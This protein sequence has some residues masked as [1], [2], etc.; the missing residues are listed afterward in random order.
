MKYQKYLLLILVILLIFSCQ[1]DKNDKLFR[2]AYAMAP[3]GTSH[4]GAVRLNELVTQK[5]KGRIEVKLY[6]GG[7]LGKEAPLIEGIQLKSVDMVI[8]GPSII[9]NYAPEYGLI[10]APFLFRDY[11]HLNNVLYGP[12]GKEIEKAV[13]KDRGLHFIDYFHRGP[14]YLTTT[15][16]IIRTPL[17]LEGLKLRVPELP[18]YIK[19][20]KIFGANPTPLDYS[21]MFIALRQGVVEG[22]ENPLEVIYSSHLYEVQ[23]YIMNTRHLISFYVLVIGDSFFDKY[24]E[25]DQKILLSSIH[26]AAEYHNKLVEEYESKYIKLLTASGSE[27]IDVDRDQFERLA[28]DNLPKEFTNE[29]EPGIY[30]RIVDTK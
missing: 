8:A 7:V 23:Q 12:I 19:S 1:S 15:N 20:W 26:E 5:S 6:P 18:V 24:S 22:Q 29:W 11:D 9:G 21:D 13:S 16:S 4:L 27:F 14:R 25:E 10:E 28:L 3:G 30:K 17:D 2:I